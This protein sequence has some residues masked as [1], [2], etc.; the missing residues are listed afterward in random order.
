MRP[1]RSTSLFAFPA[2][3]ALFT[4]LAAAKDN[5]AANHWVATWAVS[6]SAPSAEAEMR[7]RKMEFDNQTVRLITHISLGGEDSRIRLSNFYG[8]KAVAIGEVHM[9]LRAAALRFNR[10][11]IGR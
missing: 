1:T 5:P 6:P 10:R 7:R 11:R 2:V 4:L 8:A 3:L 9:A